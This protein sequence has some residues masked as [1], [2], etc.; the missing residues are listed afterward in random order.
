MKFSPI[1]LFG[2]IG[3][4]IYDHC[5]K[6][7]EKDNW[8]FKDVPLK[9]DAKFWDG[10]REEWM[11]GQH[12]GDCIKAPCTCTVCM[13]QNLLEEGYNISLGL[14]REISGYFG[15]QHIEGLKSSEENEE[16]CLWIWNKIK[17]EFMN[18]KHLLI[19]G[20]YTYKI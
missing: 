13:W 11:K 2:I 18:Y 14:A 16:K 17:K 1:E 12:C 8:Y 10:I 7:W 5:Y 3:Q 6:E 19:D 9:I 20:G 15:N 4:E